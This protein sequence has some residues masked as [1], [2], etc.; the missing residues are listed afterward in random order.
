MTLPGCVRASFLRHEFSYQELEK[1]HISRL[2]LTSSICSAYP[3]QF[4]HTMPPKKPFNWGLWIKVLV[5]W[6]DSRALAWGLLLVCNGHKTRQDADN[7]LFNKVEQSSALVG[8]R[9]HSG[10]CQPRKNWDQGTTPSSWRGAWRVERK[11]SKSSTNL[12]HSS[13]SIPNPINQVGPS[14]SPDT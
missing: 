14:N 8:Q 11:D 4:K 6:V 10:W 7:H 5:G 12:S 1:S 2:L 13:R 3:N 9:S